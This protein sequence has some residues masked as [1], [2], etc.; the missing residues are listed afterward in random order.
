MNMP[1][2]RQCQWLTFGNCNFENSQHAEDESLQVVQNGLKRSRFRL[3]AF[4]MDF[5]YLTERN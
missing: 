3:K 2:N 1:S 5:L 4:Q